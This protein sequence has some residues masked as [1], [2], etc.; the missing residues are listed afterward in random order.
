MFILSLI[1]I[2]KYLYSVIIGYS[3]I[4][5]SFVLS[6]CFNNIIPLFNL[7]TFILFNVDHLSIIFITFI[8]WLLPSHNTHKS[9]AYAKTSKA[10]TSNSFIKS[11]I[12]KSKS[13][14]E[15]RLPCNTPL[16]TFIH[17]LLLLIFNLAREY[18]N[19][20]VPII[21]LFI[22]KIVNLLKSL[23]WSTLSY[24]FFK[25]INNKYLGK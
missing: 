14:G 3:S 11:L 15:I 6:L 5:F 2:P 22:P 25:S 19:L 7:L 9:S 10:F 4:L 18:N 21:S 13:I 1:N 16:F 24:A 23:L 20:I 12:Y 8:N 17:S